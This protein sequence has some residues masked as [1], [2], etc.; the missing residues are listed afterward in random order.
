[1]KY[2]NRK[3]KETNIFIYL[4][5]WNELI[6]LYKLIPKNNRHFYE[7]INKKCKFFL[8]LDA[9]CKDIDFNEWK[10]KIEII[11]QETKQLFKKIFCNLNEILPFEN[12]K[13]FYLLF[14]L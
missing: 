12:R 4:K 2:L 13:I 6:K 3:N 10:K 5:N 8:D 7:I 14:K 1:M 11:K 9:K